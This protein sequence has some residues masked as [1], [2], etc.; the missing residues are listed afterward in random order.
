MATHRARRRP[1]PPGRC[2][3]TSAC[4][5][6]CAM[7]RSNSSKPHGLHPQRST[8]RAYACTRCRS[9]PACACPRS[10]PM[11]LAALQRF[12][13]PVYLHQVVQ[14]VAWRP[15][16]ICRPARGLRLAA[17]LDGGARVARALSCPYLP[18]P[19][20]A[21]RLDAGLRPRGDCDPS[22]QAGVGAPR[23]GNLHLGR[24]ARAVSQRHGGRGGG[25]RTRV[26]ANGTRPLES[27][28]CTAARA[29]LQPAH[30]LDQCPRGCASRRGQP[31]R[32]A[33]A[34]ADAGAFAV[35]RRRDVSQRCLRPRVRRTA[36]SG[37]SDSFGPGVRASGL[38]HRFRTA[39]A[40]AWPVWPGPVAQRKESRHGVRSHQA[41]RSPRRSCSTT[42]I[43]RAIH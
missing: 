40:L 15:D 2:T 35:L 7:P 10:T 42:R 41:L 13:D 11:T 4:A 14:N 37:A 36:S 29:H 33:A 22:R 8:W 43:T 16:A 39:G 26:G 27:D 24:A 3:I 18:R 23:S 31:G 34:A 17:R 25:A 6:T 9:V 19:A 20:G 12:D 30:G 21:V 32:S 38:R 1:R 5:S 28:A